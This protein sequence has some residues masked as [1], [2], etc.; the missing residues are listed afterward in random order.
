MSVKLALTSNHS[1]FKNEFDA[2]I[3]AIVTN[4]T[5][6]VQE[7]TVPGSTRKGW[8]ILTDD[9]DL[10]ELNIEVRSM[11]CAAGVFEPHTNELYVVPQ[12]WLTTKELQSPNCLLVPVEDDRANN[13]FESYY[14]HADNKTYFYVGGI[15]MFRE[16]LEEDD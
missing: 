14:N 4:T 8:A 15:E 2:H 5:N 3:Q 7:I 6:H 10:G 1:A 9:L 16:E 13:R 12:E 11:G